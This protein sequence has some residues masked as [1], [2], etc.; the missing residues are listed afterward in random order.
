MIIDTHAHLNFEAFQKDRKEVIDRTLKKGVLAINVGAKFNSSK[1]A[2][3]IAKEHSGMYGSIGLHPIHVD[4]EEFV[5]EKFK[6]LMG[7]DIVAIG[8]TGL[9]KEWGDFEKQKQVFLEHVSLAKEM[10]LPLILHCRKAHKELIEMLKKIEG[11][12]GVIHCFTGRRKEAKEYLDMGLFLGFNG[13]IFKMDLER[14][15]EEV[16][17][18]RILI[19]TDCPYLSPFKE[20]ERNEPLFVKEIAKEIAK[21]KKVSQSTIIEETTKN[22]KKLFKI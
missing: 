7:E 2:A 5:K 12:R 18:E 20:I 15:I 21:I 19:E 6:G 9:D 10:N 3:E 17:M 11:I 14:V 13:I 16:P 4:D 1:K 8:E 22:A